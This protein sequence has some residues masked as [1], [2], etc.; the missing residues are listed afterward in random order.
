MSKAILTCLIAF[1][2]GAVWIPL[3][4]L[5]AKILDFDEVAAPLTVGA[6]FSVITYI[7][8]IIMCVR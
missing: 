6:I 7:M 5:V 1:I 4:L 8:I 2:G 3:A